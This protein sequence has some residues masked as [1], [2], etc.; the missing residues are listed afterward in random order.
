MAD[1]I[2]VNVH[3][4]KMMGFYD[5]VVLAMSRKEPNAPGT[6]GCNEKNCNYKSCGDAYVQGMKDGIAEIKNL[7]SAAF[8]SGE[9]DA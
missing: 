5:G 4:F 8:K 6:P 3:M 1:K 2:C 9:H 7:W